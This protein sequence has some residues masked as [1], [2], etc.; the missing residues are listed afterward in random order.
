MG[1]SAS[2]PAATWPVEGAIGSHDPSLLKDEGM[3]WLVSTGRGGCVK[4]SSDGLEWKEGRPLFSVEHAWWRKYAPKMAQL[5][6]RAPDIHRWG[7]RI[8]CYYSVGEMGRNNS[9]IGLTSCTDISKG[10]WRD[11]G[12]VISSKQGVNTYN[13]I[14]PSLAVDASGKPWLV[15]GSRFDG[16]HLVSLDPA[17]MKPKGEVSS[18]A[19]RSSGIERG[20]IV[21]ANGYYYLFAS[22]D[23]YGEGAGGMYKIGCGRSK[24]ITGPYVDKNNQPMLQGNA[25]VL[26]AGTSRFVG[27]G[28]P[29]VY[30]NGNAWVITHHAF[31]TDNGG[32]SVLFVRDL[33]WDATQWPTY[34]TETTQVS[35]SR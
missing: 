31:D 35:D 3:W 8:L 18:I 7:D 2:L 28:G 11:D 5:D 17:T 14:D 4:Y 15:F 10:D 32:A 21:Y 34:L 22:I 29:N 13:A 16:L 20:N 24:E 25:T 1:L 19:Q 33:V 6:V 9:A 30:K 27:P 12:L 26:D 23:H